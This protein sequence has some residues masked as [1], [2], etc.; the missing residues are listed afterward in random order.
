[1]RIGN[2]V[3]KEENVL[4]PILFT[5]MINNFESIPAGG[6]KSVFVDDCDL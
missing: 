5:V 3:E 4:T 1:M 6:G 2:K